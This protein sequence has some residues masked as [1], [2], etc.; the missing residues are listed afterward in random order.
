MQGI[1]V[2]N[3]PL[4]LA[5]L[6]GQAEVEYKDVPFFDLLTYARDLVH[7]GHKLLSHPLSGSIKPGETPYKSV[8]VS[9]TAGEL[10]T[11][12]L[13]MIESA[14]SSCAK[15]KNR[16]FNLNEEIK[17]DYQLVDI[18]LIKGALNKT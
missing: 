1:I 10:D 5:S 13:M 6:N 2:T 16:F 14:I 8:L 12:S 11:N 9:K 7:K 15:F 3:N 4:V 17:N 18:E